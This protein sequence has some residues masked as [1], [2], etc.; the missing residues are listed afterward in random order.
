MITLLCGLQDEASIVR[1]YDGLQ[2]LCGA[3]ERDALAS[4][5]DPKCVALVSFGVAGALAKDLNLGALVIADALVDLDGN[6]FSPDAG[7]L[8]RVAAKVDVD[9]RIF[10]SNP[11]E[12]CATA[13]ERAALRAKLGA[14]VV[15]EES[16]AVAALA[17]AR[18]LPFLILRA[19]S[20]TADQ[21]VLPGDAQAQRPDGSE[22]ILPIIGDALRDPGEAIREAE[23][24]GRALD[25][26]RAA[27]RVLGPGWAF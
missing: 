18:G 17:K 21:D 11:T 7:W 23:G 20:D 1:G 9:A 19:I 25:A 3:A 16:L 8:R 12:V 24:F 6:A 14:D 2:V 27:F 22:D 5:A 15:D 4:L 13:A 26:L 10:F